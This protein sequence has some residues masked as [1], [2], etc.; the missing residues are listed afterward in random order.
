MEAIKQ[1]PRSETTTQLRAFLRMIN[2]HGKLICNLSTIFQTSSASPKNQ[3]FKWFPQCEEALKKAKDSLLSSSVLVYYDPSLPMILENDASQYGI[4]PAT[5]HHF[6]DDDRPSA[7]AVSAYVVSATEI[8]KETSR[9][10][11]LAK[12]LL[13]TQNSWPT[14]LF[15]C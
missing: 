7:Y 6:P 13:L 9:N 12:A 15:L 2:F 1:A 8:A 11:I 4:G 5:L 10:P 3:E 14:G